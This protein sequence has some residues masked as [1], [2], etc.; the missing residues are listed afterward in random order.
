MS[1]RRSDRQRACL[2]R[3]DRRPPR[4]DAQPPVRPGWW[5]SSRPL[6]PVPPCRQTTR[7][8]PPA[9]AR[10]WS[11]RPSVE[12]LPR[13]GVS[14]G[15][16][17]TALRYG[18]PKPAAL[19]PSCAPRRC[20]LAWLC[21]GCRVVQRQSAEL[22]TV[23]CGSRGASRLCGSAVTST[24]GDALLGTLSSVVSDPE[25]DMVRATSTEGKGSLDR[26]GC[27]GAPSDVREAAKSTQPLGVSE[28]STHPLPLCPYSP[29][30][31]W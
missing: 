5:G 15:A 26:L 22:P 31:G 9:R 16:I 18:A 10:S 8:A 11:G 25:G 2:V 27:S 21:A 28:R 23:Q 29:L 20:R 6:P 1:V 19:S 17:A 14:L 4:L 3:L 24:G 13:V 7:A 12:P 30:T